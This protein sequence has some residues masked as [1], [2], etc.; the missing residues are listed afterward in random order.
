[1]VKAPNKKKV[2]AP[3]S[4]DFAFFNSL[5][6]FQKA[7]RSALRK[8]YRDLTKKFLDFNDPGEDEQEAFLRRPQFEALETYVFLK[9]FAEN[10]HVHQLFEEW[11]KNEG[12]FAG[13]I[14]TGLTVEG[15]ATLLPYRR[16]I[17][18]SYR[19]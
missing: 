12:I 11:A 14:T 16:D 13:F 17:S 18:S 4:L 7:N 6:N 19:G 10:R 15:Q 2:Q 1:M 5:T 8:C 9:E 3:I